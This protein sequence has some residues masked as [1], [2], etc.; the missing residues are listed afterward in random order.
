L[1]GGEEERK[2][3]WE[4]L[5]SSLPS[6]SYG[7][8]E[9]SMPRREEWQVLGLKDNKLCRRIGPLWDSKA[10]GSSDSKAYWLQEL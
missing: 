7:G 9:M 4:R 1:V 3:R 2:E 8:Q 10:G 5:Y 6:K